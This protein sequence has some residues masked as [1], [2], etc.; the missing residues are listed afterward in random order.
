MLP[1]SRKKL[2]CEYCLRVREILLLYEC[3]LRV[4]KKNCDANMHTGLEM[5]VLCVCVCFVINRNNK[6]NVNQNLL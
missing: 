2:L 5:S 1:T 4:E 3:C 6:R